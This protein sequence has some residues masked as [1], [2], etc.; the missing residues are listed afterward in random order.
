MRLK[1]FQPNIRK[2]SATSVFT[3][4]ENI[5]ESGILLMF[6][7]LFLLGLVADLT[8]RH[9]PIPRVTLLL[10]SGFII[11]PSVLDWLPSYTVDFFP[12]LTDVAL[13][14]VG[15]LLGQRLTRQNLSELGTSVLSVAAGVV[16]CTVILVAVSLILIGVRLEIALLLAGIAT[17][18]APAATY[19][20]VQETR[21]R[22]PFTNTL[23]GVVAID[24]VWGLLIF[25]LLLAVVQ[26]IVGDGSVI[27][28]ISHSAWEIIGA[29]LLG[30]VLGVPLA[31]LTGRI[32][33]GESTHAEAIGTVFLCA[34]LSV[35]LGVSH[36]LSAI[37]AGTVIANLIKHRCALF[38]VIEAIEWPFLI[39]FFL[40]AG[41]SLHVDSL[42]EI[43]WM[44]L[45]YMV[46]RVLGRLIGSRIGGRLD[47]TDPLTRKWIGLALTPQAGVAIGMAL[48]AGQKFPEFNDV[49]LP[50]VLATTVIFELTGP[51]ITRWVLVRVGEARPRD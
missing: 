36:I 40:L 37:V 6:G 51:V 28:I 26:A 27:N 18:T 45:V 46:F 13:T 20:V 9:T 38:H 21:S 10:V 33:P 32:S 47:S 50:V 15:F 24:D 4:L 17:A 29:L 8:G 43:G 12:I 30:I 1:G 42:T 2:I 25:S 48:M 34:G 39:L 14:M 3:M 11:G 5:S 35:W 16:V 19:D 41:A 44:G 23:L 31:L 22:G 7:G 49:I